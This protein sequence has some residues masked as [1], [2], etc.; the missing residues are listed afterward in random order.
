MQFKW[1]WVWVVGARS[2]AER[3]SQLGQRA[4]VPELR[5]RCGPVSQ[6]VAVCGLFERVAG[7]W[8]GW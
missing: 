1:E 7:G 3:G 8:V 6:R 5:G 4:G 2:R